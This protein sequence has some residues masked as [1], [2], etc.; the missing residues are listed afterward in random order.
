MVYISHYVKVYMSNN[1]YQIYTVF[2]C[3]INIISKT[4]FAIDTI[5]NIILSAILMLYMCYYKTHFARRFITRMYLIEP[6][7]TYLSNSEYTDGVLLVNVC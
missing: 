6:N 3:N 2:M 5:G 7:L 1:F 4:Y